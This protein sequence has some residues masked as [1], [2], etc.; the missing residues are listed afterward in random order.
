MSLSTLG[1]SIEI[2]KALK[3]KGYENATPIQKELISSFPI[4]RDCERTF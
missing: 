2:L 4:S 3:D 1:L